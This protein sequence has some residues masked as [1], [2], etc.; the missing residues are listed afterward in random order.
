M[1][2][3]PGDRVAITNCLYVKL[4]KEYFDCPCCDDTNKAPFDL[5][6]PVVSV[7]H[8]GER[9][10]LCAPKIRELGGLFSVFPELKEV[11]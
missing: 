3:K 4:S 9:T 6:C 5:C 2:L 10:I 8:H 11:L 7:I 1:E